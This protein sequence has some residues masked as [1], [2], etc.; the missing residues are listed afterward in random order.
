VTDAGLAHLKQMKSLRTL[1]LESTK[2]TEAG[3]AEL[4]AALPECKVVK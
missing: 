1:T 3:I 4:K 2:V